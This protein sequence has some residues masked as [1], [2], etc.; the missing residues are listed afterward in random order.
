ME[1]KTPNITRTV[2]VKMRFQKTYKLSD[3]K[4]FSFANGLWKGKKPPFAKVSVVRNTNFRNNGQFDYSD[5]A[6]L[7]VEIKQYEKRK[8]EYGDIIIERSGGGPSQPVGRVCLFDKKEDGFSFSNFT[9][10]LRVID[11]ELFDSV[12]VHYALLNFY[13]R[14]GTEKIQ[15]RTTG[16]RNLDFNQYKEICIPCPPLSEQKQI[17]KTLST[18]QGAIETQDKIIA[19]IRELKKSTME[20]IF[21]K[22]LNG[23]KT[24]QTE[25]GEMPERWEIETI[26]NLFE[27][28]QGK[29]LSAKKQTGKHLKPFLRT[30]NVFWGKLDLSKV[31]KMDILP[32][33]RKMLELEKN[34]LLVCEGGDIGRTAIWKGELGECY[35]Q[36]HIHRLRAKT[37]N[38]FPDFFMFWLQLAIQ[39]K[40]TYGTFGNRTT[41]PNLSGKTLSQF[42]LPFPPLSEQK[43][44]VRILQSIDKKLE[45]HE[46]KKTALQDLF[47]TALDKLMKG[48]CSTK[49]IRRNQ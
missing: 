10:R 41:I 27:M 13:K 3:D 45:Q 16:I 43:K 5:I 6:N 31:D 28:K 46:A 25:I 14:G 23:E 15:N 30:S 48:K 17:A 1:G 8:L 33:E 7:D 39:L 2:M 22:G 38:I 4:V 34:D 35:Y 18:I 20:K 40:K 42:A 11:S 19:K 37:D 29:S 32:D 47:K 36:N 9:S 12:F 44:T 49:Q 24:K 26:G 21:T